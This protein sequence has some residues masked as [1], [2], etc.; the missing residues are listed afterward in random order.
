LTSPTWTDLEARFFTH[1]RKIL[2]M[3]QQPTRDSERALPDVKLPPRPPSITWNSNWD[4]RTAQLAYEHAREMQRTV[5]AWI[6]SLDNKVVAVFGVASG[7]ISL[8][9]SLAGLPPGTWG[10]GLWAGA[11][12]AWLVSALYCRKAFKPND[13]RLDPDARVLLDQKWLSLKPQQFLLDRLN[14]MGVSV[15]HNQTALKGKAEALRLALGW[16]VVEVGL[17]VGALLLK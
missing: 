5:E 1:Q 12:G 16:A 6:D 9:T 3:T 8:V 2:A 10:R 15:G 14:N 17:L 4:E 13:F 7:V 11:L